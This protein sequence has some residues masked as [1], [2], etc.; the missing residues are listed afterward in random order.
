M[1]LWSARHLAEVSANIRLTAV[2]ILTSVVRDGKSLGELVRT[3]QLSLDARDAALLQELTF[4]VARWSYRL[5]AVLQQLLNKSIRNKDSDVKVLLWQALYEILYMRTPD[6]AA[7]SSYAGLTA[8]LKKSWAKGLVNASLRKFLREQDAILARVDSDAC[9][10]H[11]LPRWLHDT[12]SADWPHFAQEIFTAGNRRGPLVLRANALLNSRDEYLHTLASHNIE[13]HAAELGASSIVVDNAARVTELPGFAEGKFSVQDSAAQLAAELL[14]PQPNERV[15]DA[16]AAPGGKSC[17]LLE[18]QSQIALTAL[19]SDAARM[20][21]L[22]ENMRRIGVSA[23]C[24]C[25]NAVQ[26]ENWWD[27]RQFD[28]I[29]LDAPCSALGVLRRHPDIRLLRRATDIESL[30]EIQGQLLAALWTT[31]KPGGRLIYATCSVLKQE[32]EQTIEKFLSQT[33]DAEERLITADWGHSCQHGR[34]ILPGQHDAD[35]FYYA[36]L[37]KHTA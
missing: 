26:T 36:I 25:A 2:R 35:G 7:V 33:S 10:K 4:G 9:H 6:Y 27:G 15:L 14:D 13:A 16:C 8:K 3:A 1:R 11:S 34:Q 19:D 17:H 37:T 29:L 31:L 28:A 18:Y 5:D 20:E 22:A 12:I 21:R 30:A 23:E 32:N 24:L